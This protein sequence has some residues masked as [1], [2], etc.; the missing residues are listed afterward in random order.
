MSF[1]KISSIYNMNIFLRSQIGQF[2][3]TNNVYF[4]VI[5]VLLFQVNELFFSKHIVVVK[6]FEEKN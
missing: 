5:E 2:S 6:E 1:K 4:K 3:S